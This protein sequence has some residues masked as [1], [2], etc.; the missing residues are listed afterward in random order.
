MNHEAT[1]DTKKHEEE[2]KRRR[3]ENVKITMTKITKINKKQITTTIMG[4]DIKKQS[5]MADR[6]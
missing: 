3:K 6:V 5:T 4:H 1:K 2:S